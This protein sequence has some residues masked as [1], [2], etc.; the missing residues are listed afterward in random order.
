MEPRANPI[1]VRK[2]DGGAS[3][4][5]SHL[6]TS[7]KTKVALIGS[8]PSLHYAPFDDPSWQI[9]S[10]AI[11]ATRCPRIDRIFELHPPVTWREHSKPQWPEYLRWLQK[12]R[13][14]VYMLEKHDDIPAS[15]RYPR[16]RIFGQCR[17]MIGTLHFGNQVDFMIALA[18]SEGATEIGVYGI[19]YDHPV[20]DGD[21]DEQLLSLKFW[22]GVIAGRGVRLTM[23]EG[24]P[25]F[26]RPAEIYGLESHSTMEKYV[27]R[28]Q[29]EQAVVTKDGRRKALTPSDGKVRPVPGFLANEVGDPQH[30]RSHWQEFEGAAV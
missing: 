30:A 22:L 29:R 26:A 10:H 13:V 18:L 20:K 12:S 28:L 14:P 7:G 24:C 15:V 6:L 4:P 27:A 25:L 1:V 2:A 21:R 17:S 8:A 5:P 16:E 11:C 9:W 23:P 3:A 19:H